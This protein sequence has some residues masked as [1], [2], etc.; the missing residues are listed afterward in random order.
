MIAEGSVNGTVVG[1]VSA[2]DIDSTVTAF[3]ITAGNTGGTFAINNSGAISVANT[4]AID[5]DTLPSYTL[6]ITASDGIN[7][8]AGVAVV[9]NISNT[10]NKAP[11][12]FPAGPFTV[13]EDAANTTTVG[14]VTA[15]DADGAGT[16]T[17]FNITGGNTGSA[18]A[19][20]AG[21]V[22]SVANTTAIDFESA[23]TSFTLAVTATDGTN[24]SAPVN[25][26]VNVTDVN[27]I[28]PVVNAAG[29]FTVAEDA[30]NTTAVGTVTA[31]DADTV[32]AVTGFNIAS[33]N[34]GGAFAISPGGVISVAETTA[35]D[36]ESATT[37]FTLAVTATDGTNT[38]A[39]VNVTVNV[40]DANDIAPVV[41]ACRSFHGR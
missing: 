36:F 26:T 39:P 1:T 35:I 5:F 22:I 38:S 31:T 12:I 16:I 30:A 17:G 8:S 15:T 11:V 37:S 20:S 32:G 27:D 9:V 40:T 24:T 28:A 41:N 33:G 3:S 23:T 25:V 14:T 10:N 13:A 19:I 6:T 21:G 29:P 18:F 4:T 2:T 34:T 7:T